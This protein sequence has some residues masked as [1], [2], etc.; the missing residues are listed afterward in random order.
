MKY[1][2]S[3]RAMLA[4]GLGHAIASE[5]PHAKRFVDLF[6]GSGAVAWHA[7]T[8]WDKEVLACDLQEF[9]VTLAGAVVCRDVAIDAD[10][11]LAKWFARADLLVRSHETF[12]NALHLQDR[13]RPRGLKSLVRASRALCASEACG[14]VQ[15]AYGGYYFSP[16]QALWID[17]L[18]STLPRKADHKVVALAALIQATS[19]CAASPGHTAQ[20]F[21]PSKTAGPFLVD[22]WAKDVRNYVAA[23]FR[24]IGK[25]AAKRRGKAIVKDASSLAKLLNEGDLAFIDPPYSAVHYSRFYHVL[26]TVTKGERISVSGVGR[27]PPLE[28]RPESDFSIKTRAALAFEELMSSVSARGA[29]AVVTFPAG[30]ASNGLSGKMVREIASKFF[31][32]EQQTVTTRFST[33]G[34]NRITR[35]ARKNSQELILTLSPK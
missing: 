17:C 15:H 14:P 31:R 23:S 19:R 4:N 33:L 3:K 26:E 5:V 28:H 35:E 8:Q 22:S 1:M 30:T 20:P 6:T 25:T 18:R 11:V 2:G 13:L 7:A 21:T 29:K 27:Y 24:S 9:A 12:R 16:L 34:G 10:R 32:I